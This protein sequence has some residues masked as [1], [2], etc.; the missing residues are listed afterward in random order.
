MVTAHRDMDGPGVW[1]GVAIEESF[2]GSQLPPGV[3]VVGTR[4]A[5]LETEEDRGQFRF[6]EVEVSDGDLAAVVD[7]ACRTLRPSWY[8]HLVKGDDMKVLFRGRA[9]DLNRQNPT[10]IEAARRYGMERGIPAGQLPLE[11]LFD[12]PFD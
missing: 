12:N 2:E 7:V 10:Q 11:H 1:R 9:F 6:H 5:R 8:F 4:L 3:R